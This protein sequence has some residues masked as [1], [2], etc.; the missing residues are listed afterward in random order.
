MLKSPDRLRLSTNRLDLQT[1]DASETH[2]VLALRAKE[3]RRR[4]LSH[5]PG[6]R[7]GPR[8]GETEASNTA[9]AGGVCLC[10]R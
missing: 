8:V 6:S 7:Q 5:R 4:R 10:A 3:N 2:D 9:G 1:C